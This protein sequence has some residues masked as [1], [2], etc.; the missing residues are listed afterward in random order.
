MKSLLLLLFASVAAW[1]DTAPLQYKRIDLYDGRVLKDVT[2][3]TY[4]PGTGR[5]LVIA[6]G[7]ASMIPLKIFPVSLEKQISETAPRSGGSTATVTVIQRAP[8]PVP[9]NSQPVLPTS[10]LDRTYIDAAENARAEADFRQHAETARTRA[11]RYFRYEYRVGS[12]AVRV[13]SLDLDTTPPEP[14]SGWTGRYRTTGKAYLEYFDSAGWSYSRA[15]APFEV[16]T[17]KKPNGHIEVVDFS[18]RLS[19]AIR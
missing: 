12:N 19:D 1:A 18:L 2:I 8:A 17:E 16:V 10:N 4:D 11:E 6:E 13:R 7:M 15:D 9:A 5:V 14:I 3:K